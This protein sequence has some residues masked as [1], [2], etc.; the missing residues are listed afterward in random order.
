[1]IW[2]LWLIIIVVGAFLA[3][4]LANQH[5][6][7]TLAVGPGLRVGPMPVF[8]LVLGIF[9]AGIL[10]SLL[11]TFPGWLRMRIT[12]KRQRKTIQTM[13]EELNRLTTPLSRSKEP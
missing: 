13:E 10:V 12:M 8:L 9:G 5:T 6:E 7:V 11:I 2:R 1:M 4:A 3:F